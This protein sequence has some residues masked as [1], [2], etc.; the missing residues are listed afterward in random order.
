MIITHNKI[1]KPRNGIIYMWVWGTEQMI[2]K[3]KWS[4]Q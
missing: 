2:W 3:K 1:K 4:G